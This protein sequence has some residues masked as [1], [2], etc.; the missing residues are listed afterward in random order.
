[1]RAI[2]VLLV[3]L[4]I[5]AFISQVSA[6]ELVAYYSF[7]SSTLLNAD[8]SGNGNDLQNGYAELPDYTAS[9]MAGG[10]AVFNGVDD[11]FDLKTSDSNPLIYPDG[12]YAVSMW[13]KPSNADGFSAIS[14]PSS[15]AG[16]FCVYI[17]AGTYRVASYG[18]SITSF[19][20]GVTATVGQWAHLVMQFEADGDAVAGEY[21]GTLTCYING[22]Y[23]NSAA[24]N[25]KPDIFRFGLG[26]RAGGLSHFAGTL[27]EVAIFGGNLTTEQITG[28]ATLSTTILDVLGYTAP[29]PSLVP[30]AYYSFD[31]PNEPT[32]GLQLDSSGNENNLQNNYASLPSH[33]DNGAVGGAAV[34]NGVDQGFDLKYSDSNPPIYP[35]GSFTAAAWVNPSV[36]D[37]FSVITMPSGIT[38]GFVIYVD[39]GTYR[40]GTY[41]SSNASLNTGVTATVGQWAHVVLVFEADGDAVD[42]NYTGT[43]SGYV[44]GVFINSV[45]AN[46]APYVFR[47]GL[48]NRAGGSN[49]FNGM[50]DEFTIWQTV[51]NADQ[52]AGLASKE[53]DSMSI[54]SIS[55]I[56]G[57]FN[58]DGIVDLVDFVEIAANWLLSNK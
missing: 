15:T 12:S 33:T 26:N 39:G 55:T 42:G 49:H 13:I 56:P 21:T 19:N 17:D 16:G 24:A 53:Y 5:A 50:I 58:D 20:T 37:G 38:G 4:V 40:M 3:T 10:A 11:G 51:L 9:G 7:D 25:Y 27:D 35:D 6:T 28:L 18:S 31:D 46:Y 44:D 8:D 29:D 30:V 22:V 48:A 43:L 36:V 47:F 52:I 1:M 54:P 45:A 32:Y 34:F 41:G 14:M 23:A 57:D 2:K